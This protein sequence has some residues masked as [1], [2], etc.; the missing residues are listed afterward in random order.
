[1]KIPP[2]LVYS[3]EGIVCFDCIAH[4]VHWRAVHSFSVFVWIVDESVP[5]NGTGNFFR[6]NK[7]G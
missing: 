2:V 7:L 3:A 1:M 4:D 6:E 5:G